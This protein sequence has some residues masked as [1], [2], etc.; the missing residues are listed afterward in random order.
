METTAC[1]YVLDITGRDHQGEAAHLRGQGPAV[2][3]ELPGGVI[4]WA[5]VRQT[6][7]ERLLADPRVSRS[8]RLHWPAFI[9]GK[10][11]E[12]WP[13][14]PWVANENMLFA[15]GEHHSRLRRLV[16]GAFT[17]RR[18][19]ALRPR[20]EELSAELL[21]SLA[22]VAPGTPVDLRT[23]YAE[24]LPL[25]VI[26][27]LFGVP[28]G[29]ETDAL[30]DAL[31][32]VFS[33]T[34]P[35]AEMEAARLQAFGLLAGLVAVK[36]EQPGDDLTSSLIAARD[37][38]DRL[39]EEELLGSL[40]MF[41]AAGQDTTATLIT[42]AAGAL[43]THPEQ[44]EHVREGRATWADVV[45]EAMRVHTPGAYSPLRFAVEDI[46]L[47]G[48]TIRKGDCILVDFAAGG[49]ETDRHG[50][51]ASR[52]DVL[53]TKRDVLGFGHGPHRCLGAPLGEIEAASALSKLFGLF[54]DVRLACAPEE[55]QPLPTFMLN[56]YRSLPVLL[57]PADA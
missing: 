27:E 53:R 49:H 45:S 13:L 36:R 18:S 38:G 55:L 5:V 42:N 31:S 17:L 32:T 30:S 6:Y 54:P 35:A 44:L 43:L 15:Y 12:D 1:P 50:P 21:D 47:D 2:P 29:A 51:D 46:D 34:T 11:T 14:Y 26:C 23:D 24:V 22:A 48:V 9:E 52:F 37:D 39:T 3:V 19:E 57:R 33:S 16:A 4:A 25:R 8:A 40:F 7:V 41:I 28:R 20:V 10:I 56:G